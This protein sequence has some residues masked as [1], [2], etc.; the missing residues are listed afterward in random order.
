M[1]KPG[2]TIHIP[3]KES[4]ALRGLMKVKPTADMH[5]PGAKSNREK[6][7]QKTGYGKAVGEAYHNDT[8]DWKLDIV[9]VDNIRF[10]EYRC[11]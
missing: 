3:L 9:L 2:N 10:P 8:C 6:E 5:R 4:D 1:P 7:G 11:E